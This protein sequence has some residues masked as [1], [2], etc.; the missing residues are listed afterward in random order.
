MRLLSEFSY[1]DISQRRIILL[2]AFITFILLGLIIFGLSSETYFYFIYKPVFRIIFLSSLMGF[3]FG[4]LLGKILFRRIKN[5]RI[6][7]AAVDLVF[8]SFCGVC[9]YC[10]IDMQDKYF[11][12]LYITIKEPASVLF[13]SFFLTFLAGIKINYF[14][15]VLCGDF[16]DDKKGVFP[17]FILFLSGLLSGTIL[18][19]A[20][21]YYSAY[22]Y[23]AVIPPVIILPT[24]FIIRL[25]Y[26]PS[27]LFAQE[28]GTPL[29]EEPDISAEEVKRDDLFF[30]YLNFTYI[31]IY[32]Y[33]GIE[34][35][36]KV[37][38]NL[39]NIKI[40]FILLSMAGITLGFMIARFFRSAF[41]Y[42]Y[43]E[44]L[45]PVSFLLFIILIER[46]KMPADLITGSLSF[47]P[48]LII[49]GFSLYHTVTHV[50]INYNHRN[51]FNIIDF[52]FFF[53]PVPIFITL[54]L[55]DFT[56][57]LFYT[58]FYLIALFNIVIPGIF[59]IK[60]SI[61]F[62][63][64]ILYTLLSLLIVPLVFI[65]HL[66]S[67]LTQN[68]E[69]Y[70][71]N[72]DI[73]S[74]GLIQID[75]EEEPVKKNACVFIN[76]IPGALI[77]DV[78]IRNMRRSIIPLYIFIQDSR[79]QT[80]IIDGYNKI[81]KN[82]ALKYLGNTVTVDYVPHEAFNSGFSG[83]PGEIKND[84]GVIEFLAERETKF[85]AILDTPNLY[86][87]NFNTFRFSSEYY[88]LIKEYLNPR[89]FFVQVFDLKNCRAE[90]L[91]QAAEGLKKN[92]KS[93]ISFLSGWYLT[94][95]SA[96]DPERF[97]LG[98]DNIRSIQRLL[99]GEKEL[100]SVFYSDLHILSHLLFSEIDDII[101]YLEKNYPDPFFFLKEPQKLKINR[102]LIANYIDNNSVFM[103]LFKDTNDEQSLMYEIRDNLRGKNRHL[104]YLKKMELDEADRNYVKG[105]EHQM[106][107]MNSCMDDYSLWRYLNNLLIIKKEYYY[108]IAGEYEKEKQ[109]EEARNLYRAILIFDKNDFEANYRLG[110]LC[111]ILQNFDESL[112]YLQHA[113][114]LKRN[115][116]EV[117]Y[118][119]GVLYFS[120]GDPGTALEYLYQALQQDMK[121]SSIFL[122][123]GLCHEELDHLREAKRFY[124]LAMLENEKDVNILSS[125]E[126]V[127]EKIEEKYTWKP[128]ER[129]SQSD[130]ELGEEMPLPI[131]ESARKVRLTEEE[132]VLIEKKEEDKEQSAP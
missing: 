52:S 44:M 85:Q 54:S 67:N 96:D 119:M 69:I 121:T 51:R 36:I 87:Q 71:E 102:N 123:L 49:F 23:L 5:S 48:A 8:L 12:L 118:Q 88:A 18:G 113:L 80:L 91:L 94:I 29:K 99:G 73:H 100:Q 124:E 86:D 76:G 68:N 4:N 35:F 70:F 81:Y 38:G 79:A 74:N 75:P 15:K 42:V 3:F 33:L 16:I 14:L 7:Y 31:I 55:I 78:V 47:A 40:I 98:N 64:K 24:I 130:V 110:R 105:A 58:L 57:Y 41:W 128:F 11:N 26:N 92:F 125:I 82:Q 37:F 19:I 103:R 93:G 127:D 84:K 21:Y 122:Y 13:I 10:A 72:N 6:L 129:K 1:P 53:L 28:L 116:P 120:R 104:S 50:L 27:P 77:D 95:L 20:L 22:Y 83:S 115:H 61:R 56:N 63:K 89:G 126:R 2:N 106:F 60:S 132:A 62:Y 108:H 97:Y 9:I 46:V 45:Y 112:D 17:F 131:I 65:F 111:I 117:L 107:L 39:I 109:W 101:V 43:A 25:S 30:T 114:K 59:L 32:L 66:Y 34:S 90:F